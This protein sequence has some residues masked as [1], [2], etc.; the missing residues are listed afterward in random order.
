M[1]ML[2]VGT[3]RTASRH[4]FF[5]D[6]F[7]QRLKY[8]VAIKSVSAWT[9]EK[10]RN[11]IVKMVNHVKDVR[12]SITFPHTGGNGSDISF[13]KRFC[14]HLNWRYHFSQP[15]PQSL[16]LGSRRATILKIVEEKALGTRLSF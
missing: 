7:V 14:V 4:C 11:E 16:L 6:K 10:Y 13:K 5:Q 3:C 15:R 12:Y 2:L 1:A 8:A 9:E